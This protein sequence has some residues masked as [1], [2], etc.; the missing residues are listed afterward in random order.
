MTSANGIIGS[1]SS[2]LDMPA[3]AD[4]QADD[5]KDLQHAAAFSKS[6]EFQQLKELI[7]TKVAHWQQYVPGPSGEVLAG[8]HVDVKQLSNEERGW[9]WLAADSVISELRGIVAAYEQA[10]ELLKDDTAQ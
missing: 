4:V 9:R 10:A 6:V 7:E 2:P 3:K 8:D 5:R 1:N